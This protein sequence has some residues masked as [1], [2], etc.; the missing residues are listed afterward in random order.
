MKSH[1]RVVVI[2]GGAVGVRVSTLAHLVKNGWSDFVLI[3]R[4]ELTAG[5]TWQAAGPRPCST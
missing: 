4:T 1:A 5:C 2:G 3:A